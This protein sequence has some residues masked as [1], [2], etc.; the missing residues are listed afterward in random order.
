MPNS[1]DDIL[2][3]FDGLYMSSCQIGLFRTN[4]KNGFEAFSLPIVVADP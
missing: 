3:C 2:A 4:Y 1:T